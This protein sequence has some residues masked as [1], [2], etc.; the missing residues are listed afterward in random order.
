MLL[1]K[2]FELFWV[3]L[4]GLFSFFMDVFGVM[5]FNTIASLQSKRKILPVFLSFASK[6]S[7]KHWRRHINILIDVKCLCLFR[8]SC[9][10]IYGE[11]HITSR[12]FAAF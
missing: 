9:S 1:K 8:R 6:T 2:L 5:S 7:F 4:T 3:S 12:K 11:R 10:C